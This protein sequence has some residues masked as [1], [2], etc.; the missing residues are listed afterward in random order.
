MAKKWILFWEY[1]IFNYYLMVFMKKS[2]NIYRKY[3][4]N[5]LIF[6]ITLYEFQGI[7]RLYIEAAH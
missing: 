7:V 2:S 4:E 6:I 3:I 5:I 1:P